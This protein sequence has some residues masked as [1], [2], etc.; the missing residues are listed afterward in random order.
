VCSLSPDATLEQMATRQ[1]PTS[2]AALGYTRAA[3][4][5]R[6]QREPAGRACFALTRLRMGRAGE[7]WSPAV[8]R[9][10]RMRSS[11]GAHPTTTM[12]PVIT[13]TPVAMGS[14]NRARGGS[15]CRAAAPADCTAN[16][17]TTHSAA[18]RRTLCHS[19][20]HGHRQLQHEQNRKG[21]SAKY[22]KSFESREGNYG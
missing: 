1:M 3:Q 2:S 12:T 10:Y 21:K 5:R 6:R 18:P 8:A 9:R 13:A 22:G 14:H 7:C 19:I 16:D 11:A 4:H 20:R 15:Y 17:S